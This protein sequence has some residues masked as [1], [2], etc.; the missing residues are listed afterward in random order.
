[1][2]WPMALIYDHW[3]HPAESA[4]LREWRAEL[5][6]DLAGVV[7]EIG[8]GT[9]AML[10]HYP[11]AIR[12]LVLAEPDRHMRRRLAAKCTRLVL[13]PI[14]LCEAS[15]ERLPFP[16]ASC[17]AVVSTLVLCSVRSPPAALAEVV[18]VLRP[19]GRFLFLEHVVADARS[20]RFLWQRGLEPIWRQCAGN[21]H[22]TR[23]TEREI[24]RA[25]LAVEAIERQS[26]RKVMPFLRPSIRGLA[27]K[28]LA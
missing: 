4:G 10:P 3:M 24:A 5:V 15:A 14:E 8:A 22:L 7:L 19:G 28:P 21:C 18:R 6:R 11:L 9:G 13:P 1:M 25:G 12:R 16:D 17:D 23:D 27:R 26:L 2:S 20:T